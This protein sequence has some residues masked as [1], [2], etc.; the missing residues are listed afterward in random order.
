MNPYV[1]RV[2]HSELQK[3]RSDCLSGVLELHGF[4]GRDNTEGALVFHN[5][6]EIWPILSSK[7]TIHY[8]FTN[9]NQ[10]K[11]YSE[12][13]ANFRFDCQCPIMYHGDGTRSDSERIGNGVGKLLDVSRSGMR[14]EITRNIAIKEEFRVYIQMKRLPVSFLFPVRVQWTRPE[15]PG[16]H[17]I[18][19]LFMASEK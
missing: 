8:N 13:R 7:E 17:Q 5:L 15:P 4:R 6:E 9:I 2:S 16:N 19:L 10:I 18:G 1:I 14:I 11:G 12:K 3:D